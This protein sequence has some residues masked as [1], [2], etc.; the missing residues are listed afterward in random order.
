MVGT[1]E[2]EQDH[3]DPSAAEAAEAAFVLTSGVPYV[4]GWAEA[5]SAAEALRAELIAC[6]LG[7]RLPHLRAEVTVTGAG[8]VEM[9]RITPRTARLLAR[10]LERLHR[11]DNARGRVA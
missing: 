2:S 3:A 6:G 7:G 8:V 4:A 5:A 10:L 1:Q 9:G 11:A